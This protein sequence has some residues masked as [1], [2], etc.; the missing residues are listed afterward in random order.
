MTPFTGLELFSRGKKAWQSSESEWSVRNDAW[1]ALGGEIRQGFAFHTDNEDNP[2]WLVDLEKT[3]PIQYI[4]VGNRQGPAFHRLHL[5]AKTLT[6]E[7]SSSGAVDDWRIIHTGCIIWQGDLVFPVGGLFARFVRLSLREKNYFHLAKVE[8][9]GHTD[10]KQAT[11]CLTTG[12]CAMPPGLRE[13]GL[14]TLPDKSADS[15]M[16]EM[17]KPAYIEGVYVTRRTEDIPPPRP[18]KKRKDKLTRRSGDDPPESKDLRL[19]CSPD[20]E[21][22]T[23]IHQGPL[24]WRN[25]LYLPLSG[26]LEVRF[27]R[28]TSAESLQTTVLIDPMM[29]G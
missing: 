19:E 3:M 11:A 13:A 17:E 7:I 25:A 27:L 15:V 20:G 18:K 28:L 26:E 9:W 6:V 21:A 23:L 24:I 5:R 14:N 2:W 22:W 4:V 12:V 10:E 16:L 1:Q 29:P 8:V